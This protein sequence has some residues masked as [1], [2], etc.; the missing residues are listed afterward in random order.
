MLR[1]MV[2]SARCAYALLVDTQREDPSLE[3]LD[4]KQ[5]FRSGGQQFTRQTERAGKEQ[6]GHDGHAPVPVAC[7]RSFVIHNARLYSGFPVSLVAVAGC[8]GSGS[9]TPASLLCERP[10]PNS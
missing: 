7:Q 8:A 6:L 3:G 1:S 5:L 2:H 10:S 9:C 4:F